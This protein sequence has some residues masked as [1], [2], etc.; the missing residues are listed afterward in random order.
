MLERKINS[1]APP[2]LETASKLD[3]SRWLQQR[4]EEVY[5]AARANERKIRNFQSFELNLMGCNSLGELLRLLLFELRERFA[6]DLVSV[7]LYDPEFEIQRLLERCGLRTENYRDLYFVTDT[8]RFSQWYGPARS[9][10][11]GPYQPECHG[12]LFPQATGTPTGV[13]LLPLVRDKRF[14]GSVNLASYASGRVD[15]HAATDFLQHLAAVITVCLETGIFR[16]RIKLLG[17]TDALT[18]VNNRRYFEQRLQE[19]VARALRNNS[20]LSCLFIDLDHFKAINDRYG[21]QIGDEVLRA[22]ADI[23][24][25]QV[26]GIDV[27]ARYGGEELVVLLPQTPSDHAVE[28][29]ERIREHIGQQRFSTAGCQDLRV[30]A[31]IGAASIVAEDRTLAPEHVGIQLIERADRA[32]Y[33]AKAKGRNRVVNGNE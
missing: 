31:S 5:E 8:G 24:H 30:T 33:Q 27:V 21:H 6:W 18:G 29:A 22:T 11:L 25:R 10:Q 7:M 15:V 9:P 1:L 4:L 19:E 12:T 20:A 23:L 16:E 32:V 13:T 28:V 26:R 17:L 3:Q 2:K 14:L